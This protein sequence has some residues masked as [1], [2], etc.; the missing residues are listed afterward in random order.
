MVASLDQIIGECEA[1]RWHRAAAYVEAA[2]CEIYAAL[3]AD[4]P[5]ERAEAIEALLHHELARKPLC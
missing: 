3:G 4:V 1:R 5:V 2:V